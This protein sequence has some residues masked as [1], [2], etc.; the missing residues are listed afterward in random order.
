MSQ[1]TLKEIIVAWL[2]GAEVQ[3]RRI[4]A[5]APDPKW[6]D[7]EP[8][9]DGVYFSP[10]SF[11]YRF[12]PKPRYFYALPTGTHDVGGE[13]PVEVVWLYEYFTDAVADKQ[14]YGI[15]GEII[16]VREVLPE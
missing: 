3:R 7:M 4:H 14:Q 2:N 8:F 16:H 10:A 5:I 15:E 1:P 11:E 13:S 6:V 12:K 9:K